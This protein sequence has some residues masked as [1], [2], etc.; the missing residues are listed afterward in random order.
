MCRLCKIEQ[1]LSTRITRIGRITQILAK[2][3]LSIR[4]QNFR[5]CPETTPLLHMS[6]GFLHGVKI[7]P[8]RDNRPEGFLE[9][10]YGQNRAF[11]TVRRLLSRIQVEIT[12]LTGKKTE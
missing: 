12:G 3:V 7:T 10:L 6:Q 9:Q 2:S 8:V 11:G 1:S 5:A 4:V